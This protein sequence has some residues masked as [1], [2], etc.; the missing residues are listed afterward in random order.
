M[1][2]SSTFV[3]IMEEWSRK[4]VYILGEEK[5]DIL[6]RSHVAVVG[7]GGVGA[8]VAEFLC[9]SGV[10]HIT[11]VDGDTV[12]ESNRNRQLPALCSTLGEVKVDVMAKRL[13]DINGEVNVHVFHHFLTESDA[14]DFVLRKGLFSDGL[15]PYDFVVDA[16]DTVPPKVALLASCLKHD[17]RVVSA[18]GAAGKYDPEQVRCCDISKTC[19]CGLAKAVRVRLAAMGIRHGLPVVFSP[20]VPDLSHYPAFSSQDGLKERIVPGTIS[21]MPALFGCHLAAFV[22]RSITGRI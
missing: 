19:Q 11:L 4:T 15:P 18:M 20:E 17:I 16:I 8:F 6:T 13:K 2:K 12:G 21:Y 7:V 1:A 14:E 5:Y 3:V 9:R 10:G 22:L